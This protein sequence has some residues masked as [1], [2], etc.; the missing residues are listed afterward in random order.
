M[1]SIDGS[2][3]YY[4][5]TKNPAFINNMRLYLKKYKGLN[6]LVVLKVGKI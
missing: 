1:L 2:G 3:Y 5:P 4:D 6:D